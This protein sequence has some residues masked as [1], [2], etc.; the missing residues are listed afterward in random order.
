[1]RTVSGGR[2]AADRDRGGLQP[3]TQ[4]VLLDTFPPERHGIAMAVFGISVLIA[5]IIGPTLGGWITDN[6]S[7]RWIFFINLPVAVIALG[8]FNLL[9][10]QGGSF[11]TS[12]APTLIGRR[13]QLHAPRLGENLGPYDPAVQEFLAALRAYYRQQTRDPTGARAMALQSLA[14]V[15]QHATEPRRPVG[16]GAWPTR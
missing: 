7:W 1:L 16:P 8:L 12:V 10:N 11:G 9:R 4:G 3:G 2:L 14:D 6:Y 13:E 5:P 15:R